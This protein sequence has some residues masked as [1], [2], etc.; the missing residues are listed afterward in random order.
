[1]EGKILEPILCKAAVAYGPK[2]PLTIEEV[3]VAP[4]KKGE[5]RIKV[6]ANALCHTD[7]YT[8]DGC[9]PEG[10]FPCIL[11]HEATAVVESLGEG[12]TSLKIGD[13][14]IPC[15]TPQCLEPECVFCSSWGAAYNNTSIK[16]NSSVAVWGLGAVGLEHRSHE[17]CFGGFSQRLRR[18]VYHRGGLKC[19][20][21]ERHRYP[22]KVLSSRRHCGGVVKT[23]EHWSDANKCNMTFNI[24]LPEAEVNQQRGQPYP[25]LYFLSGLE[26]T[27]ENAAQKTG[28]GVYAKQHNIAVIFPDT[29]PR[30]TGI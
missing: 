18:I 10:L 27:H 9:D 23:V 8:L 2:Q 15:Y 17:N 3:Y 28:F 5:I 25:V 24:Y 13:I 26:G 11:G 12:V 19:D 21:P 16:P 1:M 6:I 14:I 29:S 7:I 4:P 30:N 22:I 20:P